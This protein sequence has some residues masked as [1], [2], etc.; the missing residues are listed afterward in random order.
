MGR[1]SKMNFCGRPDLACSTDDMRPVMNSIFIDEGCMIA[2]NGHILVKIPLSLS[3][4][5]GEISQLNQYYIHRSQYKEMLRYQ[6]L[7]ITGEGEIT[8]KNLGADYE[9]VFKLISQSELGKFP[10]YKNVIDYKEE[11]LGYVGLNSHTL[12]TFIS[13]FYGIEGNG[14]MVIKLQSP[15][16][17]VHFSSE[18]HEGLFGLIMPICLNEDWKKIRK[19]VTSA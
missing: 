16:R 8:A 4:L 19:E 11:N 18:D 10:D 3:N 14:N 6:N 7:I 12:K 2:T 17:A 13:C 15:N 9:T 1:Q 5:F